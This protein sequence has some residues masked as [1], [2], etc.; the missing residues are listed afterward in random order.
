M[1]KKNMMT[2]QE[3]RD[4]AV[5][6]D[7]EE[8]YNSSLLNFT[9]EVAKITPPN[10]KSTE[11]VERCCTQFFELCS[12][13]NVKPSVSGFAT[14]LGTNRSTLLKWLDGSTKIDNKDIIIKAYSLLETFDEIAMKEGKIPPLIAIFNAKNN[15][16]YTDKVDHQIIG[17]EMSEEEIERRYREKH[18]IVSNQ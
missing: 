17:E 16:G 1:P 6:K 13:L 7:K 10:F 18:E 4:L 14:A 2:K 8:K 11:D 12:K 9:I 3:K 15:Y 5:K